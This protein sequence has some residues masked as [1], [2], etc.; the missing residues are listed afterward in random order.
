MPTGSCPDCG[1]IVAPSAEACPNC[2]NREFY[3]S[4]G[5]VN[6]K[7][8]CGQ[9]K[10]KGF[11]QS[12]GSRPTICETCKGKGV[13]HWTYEDHI[14][15]RSPDYAE[16]KRVAEERK[17]STRRAEEFLR[18]RASTERTMAEANRDYD[19]REARY[20][21]HDQA[22]NAKSCL[23]MFLIPAGVI[24]GFYGIAQ[25]SGLYCVGGVGLIVAY[26]VVRHIL[27]N[28]FYDNMGKW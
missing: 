1:H 9:C 24:L 4:R 12:P 22:H 16:R 13:N 27:I 21:A 11:R 26:F 23:I 20:K 2:G 14:D 25:A 5:H 3:R 8:I 28:S 15:T 6:Y 10:G 19:D 17:E 7:E 18:T